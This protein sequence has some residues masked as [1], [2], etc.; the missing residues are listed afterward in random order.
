MIGWFDKMI[1][2]DPFEIGLSVPTCPL[3][4]NIFNKKVIKENNRFVL[5][6]YYSVSEMSRR[7]D[8]DSHYREQQLDQT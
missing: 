7:L 2:D 1:N 4:T 6:G 5:P 3:L 8:Q